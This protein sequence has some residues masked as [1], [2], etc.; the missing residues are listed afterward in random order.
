MP[1]AQPSSIDPWEFC[2]QH[3]PSRSQP[4]EW[5]FRRACIYF[6]AQTLNRPPTTVNCWGGRFERMPARDRLVL[7]LYHALSSERCDRRR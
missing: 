7:A 1:L 3:L 5:G 6:L 2:L 4:D